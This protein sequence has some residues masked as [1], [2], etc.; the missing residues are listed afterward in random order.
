M[1]A[2]TF[3]IAALLDLWSGTVVAGPEAEASF[4][5]VYADPVVVNGVEVPVSALVE[6]AVRLQDTFET[7]GRE[8]LDVADCGGKVAVAFRLSGRQVGPLSTSAGV[9]PPTGQHLSMRVIDILT[10]TE[11]R[12]SSLWMTADE[13]GAL[14]GVGA[15]RVV[16]DAGT[17]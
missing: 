7:L 13:L 4:R 10:L 9:V 12:I 14:T 11:G 6:R 17:G 8:V 1:T 3:D 5:E 2:V 15:V 16:D